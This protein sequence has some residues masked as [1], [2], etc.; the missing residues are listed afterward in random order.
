MP[1]G[2]RLIFSFLSNNQGGTNHEASE[3]LDELCLA[4]ME[5]FG[6][7]SSGRTTHRSMH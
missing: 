3:V 7:K 6:V 5:E 4:M 2:R 1:D